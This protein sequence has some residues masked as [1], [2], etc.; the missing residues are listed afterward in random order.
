MQFSLYQAGDMIQTHDGKGM[1]IADQKVGSS[2][3]WIE[4]ADSE[5]SRRPYDVNDVYL[6]QSA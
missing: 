2:I 6:I 4:L 3:I 5:G 1:V